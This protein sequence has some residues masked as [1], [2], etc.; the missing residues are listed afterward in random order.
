MSKKI[1][2]KVNHQYKSLRWSLKKMLLRNKFHKNKIQYKKG[3][4]KISNIKKYK[5]QKGIK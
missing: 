4:L 3:K 1:R 2:N 5:N